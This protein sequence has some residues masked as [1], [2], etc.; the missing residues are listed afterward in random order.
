MYTGQM[1]S[2]E[3]GMYSYKA[4]MYSPS[5]G[6]FMQTDPIGYEDQFNLYGYVGNDPING[7]NPT[8][9]TCAVRKAIQR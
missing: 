8:A 9:T 5:L 6:R 3:I 1:Y 7:I 2:N 4:R